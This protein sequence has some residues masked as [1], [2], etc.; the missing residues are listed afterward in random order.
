HQKIVRLVAHPLIDQIL[1]KKLEILSP[2]SAGIFGYLF[3]IWKDTILAIFVRHKRH[4]EFSN[5]LPEIRQRFRLPVPGKA[6]DTTPH[7]K[8]RLRHSRPAATYAHA[9]IYPAAVFTF[10]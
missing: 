10:P 7:L 2:V 6:T 9:R 4:I 1:T 3:K 5:L 8:F